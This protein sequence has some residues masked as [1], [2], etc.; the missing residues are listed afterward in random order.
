MSYAEGSRDSRRRQ[1]PDGAA[2]VPRSRS[3]SRPWS[4]GSRALDEHGQ[5][6]ARHAT[7]SSEA[8][9]PTLRSAPPPSNACCRTRAGTP[10]VRS[11]PPSAV[12][13]STCSA[14]TGS[15]VFATF[16]TA[17]FIGKDEDL[18]LRRR[19]RPTTVPVVDFCKDD[20]RL[21]P[22]AFVPLVDPTRAVEHATPR[23]STSAPPRSTCPRQ[24]P[25]SD[26]PPIPTCSSSG[27]RSATRVCRSCCTSVG[28]VGFSTVRSTTTGCR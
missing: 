22:V 16:A 10:W 5:A 13:C 17:Q 8:G 25:A 7:K 9:T 27:R 2:G 18:S 19:P 4:S 15:F 26:H 12:M 1:P 14:S 6:A 28:A 20:P 21:L 11:I 24:Q 23:P 3:W